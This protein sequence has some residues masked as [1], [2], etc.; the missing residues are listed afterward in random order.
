MV[1]LFN[2]ILMFHVF[3]TIVSQPPARGPV[4][5]LASITPGHEWFSWN[6]SF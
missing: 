4:P 6:L 3:Y 2:N 1:V 5:A